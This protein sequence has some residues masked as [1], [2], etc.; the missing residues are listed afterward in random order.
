MM[1]INFVVVLK[2]YFGESID[3][4]ELIENYKKFLKLFSLDHAA[5]ENVSFR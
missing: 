3:F 1:F 2:T 5:N 4:V